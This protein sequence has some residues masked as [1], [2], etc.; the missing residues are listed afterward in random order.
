MTSSRSLFAAAVLTTLLALLSSNAL[1]LPEPSCCACLAAY[2][3]PATVNGNSTMSQP[4]LFCGEFP[5]TELAELEC[6]EQGG[7]LLCLLHSAVTNGASNPS[8]SAELA[9]EGIICPGSA[10]VP[11]ASGWLLTGLAAL[12]GAAGVFATRRRAAARH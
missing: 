2:D 3:E 8:C 12:L 5:N 7:K 6:A 4:A 10:A 11:V 9:E 1:G